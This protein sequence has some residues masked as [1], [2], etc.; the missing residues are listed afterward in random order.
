MMSTPY[1]LSQLFRLHID[2]LSVIMQKYGSFPF[3]E[4]TIS[5][6]SSGWYMQSI[7]NPKGA[8]IMSLEKDIEKFIQNV[9]KDI[10]ENLRRVMEEETA[11]LVQSGIAQKSLKTGDK[12]PNFSLPN[13]TGQILSSAELLAKGPLVVNFYRGGW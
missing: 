12:A 2:S 11:R 10:P 9:A 5:H 4:L 3:S 6:F 1:F 13:G 8:M 7:L